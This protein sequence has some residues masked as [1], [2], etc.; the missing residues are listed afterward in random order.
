MRIA[1]L[2]CVGGISG[3]MFVGALLDAGWPE[4]SFRRSVAWLGDEIAELRIET[5]SHHALRGLGIEVTPEK[6][7]GGHHHRNL[8]DVTACLQAAPL[9]DAVRERAVAVF[10]RLAEGEARAHG[11][12]VETVRFHEVGAVDAMVDVVATCQGLTDLAIDRLYVSPLPVGRGE[13]RGAHG[14]IPLPA[15]ATAHLL[16]GVPVR[17]TG[18]EGERTT[19][20]GAA[21]AT[22]LGCWEIPPPMVLEAVG[23][24]AGTR[25]L[26]DV[27]N[28]ARLFVGSPRAE[29]SP[30]GGLSAIPD[31]GWRDDPAG[32]TCPGK[33]GAVVVLEAQVDDATPEEVSVWTAELLE[34]GALDVYVTAVTMKKGRLGS[35]V[36]AICRPDLEEHLVN[37]LL[38][39]TTTLGVRRRVE[40]RRELER[41]TTDVETPFGRVAVKMAQRGSSWVGKP[42]FESCRQAALGA[43]ASFGAVWRAALA[44]VVALGD[45]Q[46]PGEG[47]NG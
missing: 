5:R 28:L 21:L 27:P 12:T 23:T 25:G 32:G 17:W 14:T 22:T 7:R 20:T 46:P 26:E 13:I 16:S 41:T 18:V 34:K 35:L 38:R 3:D 47:R 9:P 44:A 1:Y 4:D 40:W 39:S 37:L 42:E 10:R 19:P 45:W 36:T 11:K 31:W 33:W 6:S 29:A 24:G 43:G 30:T 2:D 8:A 15:P